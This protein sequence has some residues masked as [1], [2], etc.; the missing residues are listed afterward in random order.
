M[1]TFMP[2]LREAH[3]GGKSDAGGAA[4]DD[5]DIV[6]RHGWMGHDSFLLDRSLS[7]V[8]RFAR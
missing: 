1:Q 6:W 5:G 8:L 7:A 3:R 4:G 2:R